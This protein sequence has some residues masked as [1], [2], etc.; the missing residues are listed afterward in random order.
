MAEQDSNLVR[1]PTCYAT[2]SIGMNSPASLLEKLDALSAAGFE[3]I[4]LSFPDLLAFAKSHLRQDVSEKGYDSLCTAAEK[5]RKLCD[6]RNL[7]IALLQPFA[8]FEGWPHGSPERSDAFERARGW[9]R[10]MEAAGIDTLQIGSSDAQNISSSQ[11]DF[12]GDLAELADIMAPKG[13]RIAYE[14][15][16]WSTHAPTWENVWQIVKKAN[17]DNIGLCLDTFQTAGSEWG[18]PTTSSGLIEDGGL[19]SASLDRQFAES[20]KFLTL[21]IPKDKIYFLQLSDAYKMSPPLAKEADVSTGLRPRG[22]WSHDFRPFPLTD[23]YLPVVS[24]TKAVLDTGFRG[25]FSMEVFDKNEER[26][27]GNDLGVVAK[28]GMESIQELLKEASR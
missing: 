14:N 23:G 4:E 18:D 20:M 22:Q 2:C 28:R 7:K 6:A 5:A 11:D 16:C 9:I 3:A 17:R 25:W 10:I 26:K 1:V 8:N 15:W 12:A 19:D 27:Y 21:T 13:L 24:V